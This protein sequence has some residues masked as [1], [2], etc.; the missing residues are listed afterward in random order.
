M[1]RRLPLSASK[2]SHQIGW[3]TTADYGNSID[4]YY[5]GKP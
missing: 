4:S 2:S 1:S 5:T 3:R